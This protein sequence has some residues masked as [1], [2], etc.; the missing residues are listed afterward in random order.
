MS[1]SKSIKRIILISVISGGLS[2]LLVIILFFAIFPSAL[3][4]FLIPIIMGNSIQKWGKIPAEEV[5]GS[6]RLEKTAGYVCAAIV[7]L[8]VVLTCAIIVL[9]TKYM[10]IGFFPN[11]TF[12]IACIISIVYGYYRGQQAVVDSYFDSELEDTINKKS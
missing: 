2:G 7:L 5:R 8:F 4:F 9:L 6:E 3:L 12:M 1:L 10:G 11:I